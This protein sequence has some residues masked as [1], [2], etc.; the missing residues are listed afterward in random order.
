M[1]WAVLL[2]VVSNIVNDVADG[3]IFGVSMLRSC[4]IATDGGVENEVM[5]CAE[6]VG[7]IG[8]VHGG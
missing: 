8:V 6:G 4:P 5:G 7:A 3:V 2:N 1:F